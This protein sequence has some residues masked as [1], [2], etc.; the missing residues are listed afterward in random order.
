MERTFEVSL[1]CMSLDQRT[2]AELTWWSSR[3]TKF[4]VVHQGRPFIGHCLIRLSS[5]RVDQAILTGD[6]AC[7]RACRARGPA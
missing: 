2:V 6:M 3:F 7:G 4:L 1:Y 5:A